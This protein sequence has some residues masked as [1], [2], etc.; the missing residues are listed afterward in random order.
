MNT[1]II[2][3]FALLFSAVIALICAI[4]AGL[5]SRRRKIELEKYN[6]LK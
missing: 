2:I 5:D 4:Y 6:Y 1:E 3:S